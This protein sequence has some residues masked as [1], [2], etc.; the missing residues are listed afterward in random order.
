MLLR[1]GVGSEVT[2]LV[3]P[4]LFEE[5]NR[6]RRF[7]VSLMRA[8]AGRGVGSV[9]PDLPGT[10][11][12]LTALADVTMIDWQEAVGSLADA[13]RREHGRCLTVAI[14]GG[15]V[16][17]AVADFGWRLAP[18][19]G[20]RVVRDLVRATAFSSGATTAEVDRLARAGGASLAGHYFSPGLYSELI[21][22]E[23]GGVGRRT[24]RLADDAGLRDVTLD[25][26]RLWRNAEPGDDAEFAQAVA[27]DVS[28]W[29]TTCASH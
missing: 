22:A 23:I 8:L 28:D 18:E 5:A 27:A 24:A 14:R 1:H 20:E 7:T 11:E 12:S 3:L 17:D 21:E 15:A 16:M 2:V 29:A 26:S 25:G 9:L 10:G 6:M 19:S 13:H 4:A